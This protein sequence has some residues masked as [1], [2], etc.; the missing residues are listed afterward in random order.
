MWVA[1]HPIVVNGAGDGS[2]DAQ[3]GM[4]NPS[5]SRRT[6]QEFGTGSQ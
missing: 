5:A 1:R 4:N 6:V 3:S 2:G